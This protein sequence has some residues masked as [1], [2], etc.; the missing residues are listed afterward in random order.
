MRSSIL[1]TRYFLAAVK[2]VL[3]L[4]LEARYETRLHRLL[5]A[6][7]QGGDP[8]RRRSAIR[9]SSFSNAISRAVL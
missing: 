4:H 5:G 8:L 3:A 2:A 1:L 7:L 9:V 6:D